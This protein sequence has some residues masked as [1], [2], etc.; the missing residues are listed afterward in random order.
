MII[1]RRRQFATSVALHQYFDRVFLVSMHVR[2]VG[3]IS[4]QLIDI[5]DNDNN[6]DILINVGM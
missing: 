3:S 2:A 1:L 6:I 5:I 4:Y